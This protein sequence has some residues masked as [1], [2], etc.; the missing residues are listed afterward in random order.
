MAGEDV[1]SVISMDSYFQTEANHSSAAIN[2]DHPGHLDLDQMLADLDALRGGEE[3]RIPSYDFRSMRQ[4]PRAQLIAPT[5][6]VVVEGLFVLGEPI[7][8]RFDLTCFLDV[9]DDQRLL[10]RI[11]R[12]RVERNATIE[13][14][15]DRY[16][17]F[18]RPSY[19]VFVAPAR[20]NADVVVDFT[21]RRAFFARLLAHIVRDY[22]RGELDLAGLIQE[23]RQENYT[24][25][26]RMDEGVMPT[27][28]DLREL[29]RAYPETAFPA[30]MPHEVGPGALYLGKNRS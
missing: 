30:S 8:S 7:V 28:I 14:I 21:F 26:Y 13:E 22:T 20:Q 1:V 24:I 11:L 3:A 10:G 29:A 18:V 23:I 16:Q 15:V 5:P 12:D 4:T 6:V 19:A 27:T 9:A 25:G 2:F 17:R